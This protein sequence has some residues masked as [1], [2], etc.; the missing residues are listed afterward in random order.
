MSTSFFYSYN[1]I[2]LSYKYPLLWYRLCNNFM[3]YSNFIFCYD[4]VF[5]S[6]YIFY[7]IDVLYS[8]DIFYSSDVLYSDNMFYLDL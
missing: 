7:S 3:F 8:N 1:L 4:K 6:N 2:L 5:Y